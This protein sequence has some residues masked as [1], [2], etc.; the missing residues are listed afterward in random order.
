MLRIP[1][2][3]LGEDRLGRQIVA[4]VQREQQVAVAGGVVGPQRQRLP[5]ARLALHVPALHLQRHRQVAQPAMPVLQTAQAGAMMRFRL[6][7]PAGL[8]EQGAEGLV[9]VR[10]VRR[11]GQR[12]PQQRFR[13]VGVVARQQAQRQAAQQPRLVGRQVAARA[14]ARRCASS[15]RFWSSSTVPRLP[16]AGT[17]AGSSATGVAIGLFGLGQPA[18]RAQHH[19]KVG[20]DVRPRRGAL[21][22]RDGA[23]GIP[24]GR[25]L[26]SPST[27]SASAWPGVAGERQA[28]PALRPA[29][30]RPRRTAGA[31]A[32]PR[33]RARCP[34]A[35]DRPSRSCGRDRRRR[36]AARR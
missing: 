35:S 10:V 4:V 28:A 29:R 23:A 14:T 15:G 13:R 1:A 32:A 27:C 33:P 3:V 11:D 22:Q 36:A 25:R 5:V 20:Q 30:D 9:H 18:L 24:R 6:H 17:N 7:R 8:P 19:A 26:A 34:T 21:Q 2:P 31:A 12:P 16:S